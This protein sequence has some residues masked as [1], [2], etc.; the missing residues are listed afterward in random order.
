MKL[1]NFIKIEKRPTL[2]CYDDTN[3]AEQYQDIENS[4]FNTAIDEIGAMNLLFDEHKIAQ[5]FSDVRYDCLGKV[6]IT[7]GQLS[8]L[9]TKA[10]IAALPTILTIEADDKREGT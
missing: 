4:G 8:K 6:G 1:A 5:I 10:L 9:Q 7:E 2:E 3:Q